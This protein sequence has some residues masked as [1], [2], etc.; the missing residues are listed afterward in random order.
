MKL[1]LL[2]GPSGNGGSPRLWV[3]DDRGVYLVQG[4]KV[5]G[6]PDH[7]EIPHVLLTWLQPDTHLGVQ[8]TDTGSGWFTLA[9]PVVTDPKALEQLRVPSHET[10]IEVPVAETARR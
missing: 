10:C 4:Y 2:G 1:Q 7:V 6:R 8:L 3:D 9:G 5:P